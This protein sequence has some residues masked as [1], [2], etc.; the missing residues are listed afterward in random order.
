MWIYI[1]LFL[2]F[3]LVGQRQINDFIKTVSNDK[4]VFEVVK[5]GTAKIIDSNKIEL[6]RNSVIVKSSDVDALLSKVRKSKLIKSLIP[7]LNDSNKDWYANV[8]LYQITERDA[9]PFMV[10]EDRE[11]WV[12]RNREKDIEYWNNYLNHKQR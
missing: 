12:M 7:L 1:V 3:R 8:L 11:T 6:P 10:I 5:V 4:L 2:P 9:T